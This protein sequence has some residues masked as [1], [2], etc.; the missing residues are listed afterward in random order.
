MRERGYSVTEVAGGE[1][2]FALGDALDTFDLLITD[3]IMRGMTGRELADR[4]MARCPKVKV[5]FMSGYSERAMAKQGVLDPGLNFLQKPFRPEDLLQKVAEIFGRQETAGR[6]LVADDDAQVRSFLATL[7]G[8][9]GYEVI[10]A[11]NG[12]EAQERCR[13]MEFDLVIT[14][15]VMPEQEGL[16]T[17]HA[18]SRSHPKLPVIAVSGAFGGAYL[19]LAHRLGARSILRKPFD[20]DTIL[21]EVRRLI[22]T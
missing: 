3:V 14:D 4:L 17:I 11:A 18:I 8:V 7:L 15:L 13:E 5:L 22:H 12:R 9:E 16:E 20:P 21:Y 2:A 6:I 19:N 10:Q 1:E